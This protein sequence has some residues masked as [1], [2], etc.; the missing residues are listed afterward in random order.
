MH[1]NARLHPV[2]PMEN[3]LETENNIL[4]VY[5]RIGFQFYVSL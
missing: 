3:V 5:K 2:R 4:Q 1:I